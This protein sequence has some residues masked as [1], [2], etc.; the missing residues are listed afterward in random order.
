MGVHCNATDK[1]SMY[2]VQLK[3]PHIT[4]WQLKHQ[5]KFFQHDNAPCHKAKM[6]TKWLEDH[7]IT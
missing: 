6:V 4:G 7:N 2:E 1:L 5:N 3:N